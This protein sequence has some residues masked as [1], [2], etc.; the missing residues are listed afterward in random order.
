MPV[1]PGT[2]DAYQVR[3][4][5]NMRLKVVQ[6]FV[7]ILGVKMNP[8]MIRFSAISGKVLFLIIIRQ[9]MVIMEPRQFTLSNRMILVFSIAVEMFGSGA[10]ISGIII[11]Y[12]KQLRKIMLWLVII[13]NVFSKEDLFF[14]IRAIVTDIA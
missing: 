12:Q 6:R 13:M 5:G 8:L 7:A 14:A 9:K 3:Q 1:L 2:V 4:N 10:K 11:P